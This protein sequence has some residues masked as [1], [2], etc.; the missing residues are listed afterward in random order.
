[1]VVIADGDII[2]NEIAKG[3]PLELG[4]NKWTNQR[5]GNKEFLTEYR[6][7]FA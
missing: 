5:Y 3:S 2:A 7:L 6:K 4:L 1:M